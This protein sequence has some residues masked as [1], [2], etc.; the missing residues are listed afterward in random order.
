VALAEES[1]YEFQSAGVKHSLLLNEENVFQ[2]R[3]GHVFGSRQRSSK[4]MPL[5]VFTSSFTL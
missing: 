4:R 1:V 2:N 3:F 5:S